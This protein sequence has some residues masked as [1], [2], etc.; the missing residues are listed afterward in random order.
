MTC[1]HREKNCRDALHFYVQAAPLIRPLTITQKCNVYIRANNF[2]C[3][4]V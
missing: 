3:S 4:V 2:V 1:D